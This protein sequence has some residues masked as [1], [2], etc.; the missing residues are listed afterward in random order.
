[1]RKGSNAIN[2]IAYE[3]GRPPSTNSSK[4]GTVKSTQSGVSKK[5]NPMIS[6]TGNSGGS[7]KLDLNLTKN[8]TSEPLESSQINKD[9]L[10]TMNLK[11]KSNAQQKR[12]TDTKNQFDKMIEGMITPKGSGSEA[13]Q[14]EQALRALI[15]TTQNSGQK[16][17]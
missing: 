17:R 2:K 1:M 8:T 13:S 10:K 15:K 6:L 16:E 5:P 14:G 4:A 11:L 9:Y 7:R 12:V 3:P